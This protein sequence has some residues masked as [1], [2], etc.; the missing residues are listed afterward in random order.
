MRHPPS[1]DG[2]IEDRFLDQVRARPSGTALVAGPVT[3][4]YRQL[5]ERAASA[6]AGLRRLGVAR[7]TLVGLAFDR[8]ADSIVTL[9]AVVLAGGAYV[10]IDPAYPEHRIRQITEAAGLRLVVCPE[11]VRERFTAP[12]PART[13]GLGELLRLGGA[14]DEVP[15]PSR[16]RRPAGPSP[17]AYVM[18]TSGSTGRPK[19]VMVEHRGVL[20]LVKD[21]DYVDL[22]PGQRMLQAASLAFDAATFEIWGALLNGASLHVVDQETAV[23]PWRF[24]QAVRDQGVTLAWITAPLFHRMAQEDPAA[25]A[26]LTTL[27]TGGDVVSPEHVR[28]V[29]EACPSLTVVNGYGPTENTTFT[30]TFPVREHPAGPLP[31]GRPI[32]GTTVRVCDEAGRPVPAG[33]VGE[34]YTGGA[35]L[36]RGY[37]ADPELTARK[38]VTLDGV[39]HYRTGDLVHADED[40]L[41]HFHGRQDDQVKIRGHLVELAEVNAAL[42][43]LPG[44]VDAHTRVVGEPGG[45]RFLTA[46]VVAPD[47]GAP[48]IRRALR[49]RLPD[50]LCPDRFVLLDRLPLTPSG[51]VDHRSLPPAVP[52]PTTTAGH[53]GR[54][55]TAAEAALAERWADVLDIDPAAIGPDSDFF[56]L[57]G[58]SLR[59]GVLLGRLGRDGAAPGYA[60]AFATPTLAGMARTIATR[61]SAPV[62]DL[63]R[64]APGAVPLHPQQQG[65]FT[66]WQAD[67]ESLA[68][69]IP[70]RLELTGRLDPERLRAALTTVVARHEA[71]RLQFTVDADG[72]HQE[73]APPAAPEFTF[74]PV[75]DERILAGFVRP[76]RPYRPDGAPLLRALLAG[77]GEPDRHDLHLDTH[78]VVFDGVSLR[79]LIEDL[80]AAYAGE[81]LPER[82]TDYRAAAQWAHDR[83]ARGDDAVDEAYWLRQLAGVPAGPLLPSDRPRGPQR[84]TRGAVIG[85]TLDAEG[86]AEVRAA[87]RRHR[88]TVFAVLFA[89]WAA[90]LARFSGRRDFTV[91]TPTSGRTHPH[92]HDVVG[93][94]VNT[95]CLRVRLDDD[96]ATLGDLVVQADRLAREALTHQGPPFPRLARRLGAVPEPGRNPLFDVLFALQDI[97]F[98]RVRRAGLTARTELV[99]PGTTR[100]DLN[101]QAY[102]RP[103]ELRLDLEY[104]TDLYD[105][106]SVRCLLDAYLE[107]VAELLADPTAPVLRAGVATPAAEIPDF[108]L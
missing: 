92:L 49:E 34:L 74:L 94:F 71:L 9:L 4:T 54:E 47:A 75:P 43:A 79:V 38:F 29:R 82:P 83:A 63:P 7:E 61:G 60:E 104:A 77:T 37:L 24:A 69:N 96:A 58:N 19:G 6:A 13:Y 25:F 102:L 50:Y 30:T 53:T 15:P 93:M 106:A 86:R 46:Y 88:T 48:V 90:T 84:A 1:W 95:A 98:H 76:F 57:G 72:V 68:Y 31:I 8:S 39:R 85:T 28:R 66:I 105:S 87:A 97:D 70:V 101:L 18:F 32:P 42:L 22:S 64:P 55:L 103:D 81:P 59:L 21:T 11:P 2:L 36:A 40:G 89:A 14:P 91:G 73:P 35:G 16:E 33:T 27:L 99:N 41:L 67:P 100:F 17:L 12:Q 107:A 51:K 80:L 56:E 5:Y 78:H 3:L 62:P 26:S 23:V 45:E 20:R 44:V 65:L 108:D 52:G 10:P